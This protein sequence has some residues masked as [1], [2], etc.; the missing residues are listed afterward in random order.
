MTREGETVVLETTGL[1]DHIPDVE[2]DNPVHPT[3]GKYFRYVERLLHK[4]LF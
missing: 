4:T 1:T 3:T 2:L